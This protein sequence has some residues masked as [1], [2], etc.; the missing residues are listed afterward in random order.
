MII[1]IK[2]LID[3]DYNNII[4]YCQAGICSFEYFNLAA[5]K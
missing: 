5:F 2:L 3:Y 1:K 4:E